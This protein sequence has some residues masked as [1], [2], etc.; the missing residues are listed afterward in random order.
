MRNQI[1]WLLPG[2]VIGFVVSAL[3]HP[4][5]ESGVSVGPAAE[6]VPGVWYRDGR[7]VPIMTDANGRVICSPEGPDY[8]PGVNVIGS[9][10]IFGSDSGLFQRAGAQ[11]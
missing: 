4:R 2:I 5:V 10:S 3:L 1:V 9:G 11:R 6:M 7:P 8:D